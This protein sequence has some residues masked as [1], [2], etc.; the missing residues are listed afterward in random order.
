M[1]VLNEAPVVGRDVRLAL[2]AVDDQRVDLVQVFG[3]KLHRSGEAC[4][5]QAHQ[6][7]GPDRVHEGL[8][9]GHLGRGDGGVF[10]LLA[11]GGDDHDRALRWGR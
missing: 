6:A 1:G 8:H 10:F 9:I 7:A 4:A 11:V 3:G 2:R 5:A